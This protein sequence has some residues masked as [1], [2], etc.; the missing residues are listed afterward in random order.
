MIGSDFDFEEGPR[1]GWLGMGWMGPV[2]E[3][4]RPMRR[5]LKTWTKGLRS[6]QILNHL[7]EEVMRLAS[8]LD[9]G[10]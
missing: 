5:V 9:V 7:K 1:T 6:S 2:A 10:V 4:K 8:G 3:A